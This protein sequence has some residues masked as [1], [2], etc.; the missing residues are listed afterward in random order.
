MN[1]ARAFEDN[2]RTSIGGWHYDD[3]ESVDSDAAAF[4]A[5]YDA[6][7]AEVAT[8]RGY[9]AEGVEFVNAMLPYVPLEAITA[10]PGLRV[11]LELAPIDDKKAAE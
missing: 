5:Q 10:R 3:G 2:L 11:W 4:I 9:I 1:D 7:R 8:L 6:L